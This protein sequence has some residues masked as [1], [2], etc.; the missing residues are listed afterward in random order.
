MPKY[1]D[2]FVSVVPKERTAKYRKM[3]E[4]GRKIWIKYGGFKV[5]VDA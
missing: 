1:V 3:A 5:V 2:G 4:F